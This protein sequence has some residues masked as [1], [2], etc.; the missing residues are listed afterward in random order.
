MLIGR[1][2]RML[3]FPPKQQHLETIWPPVQHW[4]SKGKKIQAASSCSAGKKRNL[5]SCLPLSPCYCHANKQTW[6]TCDDTVVAKCCM[7]SPPP[8]VFSWQQDEQKLSYIASRRNVGLLLSGPQCV[9]YC[10]EVNCG[11]DFVSPLGGLVMRKTM[12]C[13]SYT[14]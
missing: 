14:F 2:R 3:K 8:P 6:F 5:R 10:L 1:Y 13:N 7:A 9:R 11:R 12:L 4:H